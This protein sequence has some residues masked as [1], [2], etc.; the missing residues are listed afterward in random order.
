MLLISNNSAEPVAMTFD[1]L[2][3][4]RLLSRRHGGHARTIQ[5]RLVLSDSA[6]SAMQCFVCCK[7][8]RCRPLSPTTGN[9]TVVIIDYLAGAWG[10][11]NC[12]Q[13]TYTSLTVG[14]V[15]MAFN[16]ALASVLSQ[17]GTLHNLN[18]TFA[19]STMPKG[20]AL[21]SAQGF[22]LKYH[23]TTG[24]AAN[25][26]LDAAYL[27]EDACLQ[28][29][30]STS[31]VPFCGGRG[32]GL[33]IDGQCQCQCT[34]PWAGPRCS[35]C[36]SDHAS[37]P[38]AC[39]T[40]QR[41][42]DTFVNERTQTRTRCRNDAS[43]SLTSSSRRG[44][45]TSSTVV[46][47]RAIDETLSRPA[48]AAALGRTATAA[49]RHRL[50]TM[51]IPP[52]TD[53]CCLLHNASCVERYGYA[54][55]QP[56]RW[57]TQPIH[58]PQPQASIVPPSEV[59]DIAGFAATGALV[60]ASGAGGASPSMQM[61]GLVGLM[62]C[63]GPSARSGSGA[64]KRTMLPFAIGDSAGKYIVAWLVLVGAAAALQLGLAAFKVTKARNAD[65][66][67]VT[68]AVAEAVAWARFPSK[69]LTVVALG[70][71]GLWLEGLSI[72]VRGR[73]AADPSTGA[74]LMRCPWQPQS[75]A[76]D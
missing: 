31:V 71:Q 60:F 46:H 70:S 50:R 26:A 22:L 58:R 1:L 54:Q 63:A 55:S 73:S 48:A 23:C 28:S 25:D 41:P 18:V 61:L 38:T 75:S 65:Q 9:Q 64:A 3:E 74:P 14:P 2:S 21:N 52:L 7:V 56:A 47:S 44:L 15:R 10:V 17:N 68:G 49:R 43:P 27:L 36:D 4:D 72:L 12:N 53:C 16:P 29:N 11:P 37:S 69:T 45:T 13:G 32:I 57:R 51:T 62:G 40:T 30:S 76:S 66:Q 5:T 24:S 67:P 42:P 59:I 34:A 8:K 19:V 20:C 33:W 6:D 35:I 39:N